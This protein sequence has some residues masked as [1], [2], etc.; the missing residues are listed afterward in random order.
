MYIIKIMSGFFSSSRD[1]FSYI[2]GFFSG[3]FFSGIHGILF[4]SYY[5]FYIDLE[6]FQKAVGT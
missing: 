1:Y 5:Y 2:E 3:N 4:S 6:V